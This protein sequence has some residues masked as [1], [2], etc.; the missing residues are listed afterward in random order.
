MGTWLAET[1]AEREAS[2]LQTVRQAAV[3]AYQEHQPPATQISLAD[4][5]PSLFSRTCSAPTPP[6]SDR[7]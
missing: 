2:D 1:S 3:D 6:R 5:L 7:R 4:V